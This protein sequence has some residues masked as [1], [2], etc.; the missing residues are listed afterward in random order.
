[1]KRTE[2]LKLAR[3]VERQWSCKVDRNVWWREMRPEPGPIVEWRL[4][5]IRKQVR[6][7]ALT[8]LCYGSVTLE[9]IPMYLEQ[10]WL[11]NH[12]D[13][14]PLVDGVYVRPDML[15]GHE[16][17]LIRHGKIQNGYGNLSAKRTR[18]T[19]ARR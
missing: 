8:Q 11:E 5:K 12:H 18:Q 1:V 17:K 6:P 3:Q 7:P 9:E 10:W 14:W 15:L 4:K 16:K 13:V 2:F 19:G